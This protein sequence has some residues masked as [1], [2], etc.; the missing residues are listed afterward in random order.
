MPDATNPMQWPGGTF[1]HTAA[2]GD[3]FENSDMVRINSDEYGIAEGKS[4]EHGS[5]QWKTIKKNSIGEVLGQDPTTGWVDCAFPIH[6][7]GPMEPYHIRAWIEP[8]NLTKMPGIK[9][10]GPWIKRKR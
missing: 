3:T 7:S 4:E 2:A 10:P 1:S 5:G 8:A 6:D 9:K